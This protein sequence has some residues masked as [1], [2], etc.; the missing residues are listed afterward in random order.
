MLYADIGTASPVP[1]SSFIDG[2]FTYLTGSS[3]IS[4]SITVDGYPAPSVTLLRSDLSA[5]DSSKV[6]L[7]RRSIVLEGPLNRAYTGNYFLL[8]QNRVGA[9]TSNVFIISIQRRFLYF[10]LVL[11]IDHR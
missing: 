3:T 9:T 5:I 4:I 10:S 1:D 11:C 6:M 2:A 8:T 7:L